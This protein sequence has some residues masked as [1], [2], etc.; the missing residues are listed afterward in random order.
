MRL[1]CYGERRRGRFFELALNQA[2]AA[3][4]CEA[5]GARRPDSTG[6][7][8]APAGYRAESGQGLHPSG[9]G[10]GNTGELL[11]LQSSWP[12]ASEKPY[13]S[14][15]PAFGVP[16]VHICAPSLTTDRFSGI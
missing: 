8:A 14:S 3:I 15:C 1:Y 9:T 2:A 16:S 5:R 13:V 12:L 7:G 10:R 6:A 4:G 11:N